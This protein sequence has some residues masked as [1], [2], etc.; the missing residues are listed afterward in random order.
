VDLITSDI[1]RALLYTFALNESDITPTVEE[2]N[3]FVTTK[4]PKASTTTSLLTQRFSVS[5]GALLSSSWVAGQPEAEYMVS[6]GW[7]SETPSGGLR[8]TSS[9]QALITF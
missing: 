5:M 3:K 6:M 4:R 7:V 8:V 1:E 9:G 2:V